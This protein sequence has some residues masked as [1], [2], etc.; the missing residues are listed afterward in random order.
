[1]LIFRVSF[2]Q[3]MDPDAGCCH[4]GD[5]IRFTYIWKWKSVPFRIQKIIQPQ[6]WQEVTQLQQSLEQLQQVMS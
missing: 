4:L 5:A 2:S 3:D 1:M 6:N